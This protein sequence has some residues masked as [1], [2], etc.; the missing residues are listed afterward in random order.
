MVSTLYKNLQ[1]FENTSLI[2]LNVVNPHFPGNP[3]IRSD[4]S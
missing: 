1:S 4:N 3:P 2:F